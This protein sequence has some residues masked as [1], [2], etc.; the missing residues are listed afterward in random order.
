MAVGAPEWHGRNFDA[1]NDSIAGGSINKIEVP[2]RIVIRNAK[3][4]S[5]IVNGVLSEL[6]DF[7]HHMQ[8]KGCP[9]SLTIQE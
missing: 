9:V 1:L 8:S 6:T 7:F 4:E 2:Y 3:R 5:A